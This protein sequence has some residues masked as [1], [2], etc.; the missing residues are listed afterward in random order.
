MAIHEIRRIQ[1]V[2][3]LSPRISMAAMVGV[4]PLLA[5]SMGYIERS[6]TSGAVVGVNAVFCLAWITLSIY[7]FV[8]EPSVGQTRMATSTRGATFWRRLALADLVIRA[9]V[10]T[11][12]TAVGAL[13]LASVIEPWSSDT[14]SVK[15]FVLGLVVAASI[16]IRL[17]ASQFG[18]GLGK[19]VSALEQEKSP[20]EAEYEQM[21]R[22]MHKAYPFVLAVWLGVLFNA[23]LSIISF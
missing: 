9:V 23:G 1:K 15:A 6:A 21:D 19:V 13:T 7:R 4:G 17:G 8:F 3:D 14:L 2:L 10:A 18:K 22:G 12:F 11:G 16:G 20:T 5:Y